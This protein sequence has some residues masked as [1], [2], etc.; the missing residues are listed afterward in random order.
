MDMGRTVVNV[1][2]NSLAAAVVSRVEGQ[3]DDQA[4][5]DVQPAPMPT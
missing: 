4:A 1:I 3:F 2:G 5:S